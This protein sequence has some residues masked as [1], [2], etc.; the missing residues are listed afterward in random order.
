MVKFWGKKKE[1]AKQLRP[2]R[3]QKMS[4]YDIQGWLNACLMELGATYDQWLF[5]RGSAD[6]VTKVINLVKDLWDE[7][8]SRPTSMR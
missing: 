5:H 6:E 4:D 1:V 3:M 2:E 7:L 8:Q